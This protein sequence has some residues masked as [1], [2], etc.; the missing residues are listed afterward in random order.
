[1]AKIN[2]AGIT[3]DVPAAG[4]AFTGKPYTPK[5]T[6]NYA[7]TDLK[8]NQDYK[9]SYQNNINAGTATV[10]ITG[11][12]PYTD[13]EKDFQDSEERYIWT[14]CSDGNELCL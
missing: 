4:V 7:G 5:C 10:V 3:L 11:M 6:V 2:Q 13:G 9:L 1:M 14:I 8:E 12:G